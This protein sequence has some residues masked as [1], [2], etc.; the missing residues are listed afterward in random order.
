MV[1]AKVDLLFLLVDTRKVKNNFFNIEIKQVS[2]L[3]K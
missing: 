3:C 1:I 2:R